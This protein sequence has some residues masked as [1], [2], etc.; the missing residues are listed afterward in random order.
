MGRPSDY[1]SEIA[2]TICDRL[3]S[4]ET[5]RAICRDDAMPAQSSVYLWLRTHADFSEQYARA[6]EAQADN[7]ADEIVEISDDASN[8]YME[9]EHGPAVN[10]EHITRSRLRVDARKWLMSKAAPKKYGD[11]IDHTHAAPD[12]GPVQIER[13]ERVIVRPADPDAGGL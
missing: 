1:G 12:G 3:A 9:R 4:G 13:I 2:G 11:K 5:L 6:R 10:S 7:W 8:D